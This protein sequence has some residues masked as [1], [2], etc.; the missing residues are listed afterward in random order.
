[1]TQQTMLATQAGDKGLSDVGSGGDGI[2]TDDRRRSARARVAKAA[3]AIGVAVSISA[4][5]WGIFSS[6]GVE[7]TPARIGE[8]VEV[9]GGLVRVDKITPE[10]MTAM[11][12]DKFAASGMNMSS[13]GMDMAPEGQRRFTV[14]IALAAE[15]G[16]LDYSPKDFRLTGTGMEEAGPI[17]DALE[18][19]TIPAGGAISGGLIFQVPEDAGNLELSFDGSRPVALDLP[20]AT[21][22][23]GHGHDAPAK[24]QEKAGS[25]EDGHDH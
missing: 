19:E 18:G 11:E 16:N 10:R 3:L 25:H 13:M 2:A 24:G 6:L 20:P 7:A 5:A 23:E 21:E 9:T 8:P 14:D 15:G 1:M 12:A 17:R 4:G 22:G